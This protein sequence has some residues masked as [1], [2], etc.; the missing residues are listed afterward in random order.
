MPLLRSV[1]WPLKR[2]ECPLSL[3]FSENP[4][5]FQRRRKKAKATLLQMLDI[6]SL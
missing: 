2:S 5:T 4:S 3:L 6:S 1:G